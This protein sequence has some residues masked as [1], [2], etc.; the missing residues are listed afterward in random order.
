MIVKRKIA[1]L[2]CVILCLSMLS[3][4]TLAISN[5]ALPDAISTTVEVS[6][7]TVM[8]RDYSETHLFSSRDDAPD[9]YN[10]TKEYVIGSEVI[11]FSGIIY[12]VQLTKISSNTWSGL[13]EGTLLGYS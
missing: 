12:L 8:Y 1:S 3:V 10:V 6:P 11:K 5:T 2:V 9:Y 4:P 7:R 13:Y